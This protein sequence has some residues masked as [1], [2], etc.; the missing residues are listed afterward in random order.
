MNNLSDSVKKNSP[1]FPVF[2]TK[3]KRTEVTISCKD[4]IVRSRKENVR[5]CQLRNNAS[6]LNAHLK[7]SFLSDVQLCGKCG[8]YIEDTE[9]YFMKRHYNFERNILVNKF[10]NIG[11]DLNLKPS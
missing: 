8:Y 2:K 1:S 7:K 3:L 11:V 5:Y 6:N 4:F 10:N 9:H